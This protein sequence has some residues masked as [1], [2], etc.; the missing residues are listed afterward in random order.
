MSNL[1]LINETEVTSGV[2]TVNVTDV[3]STDF[4]IYKIT[5]EGFYAST[6]DYFYLRLINSA[7]SVIP[8][9]SYD[10]ASL[11]MRASGAF[12][13]RRGLNYTSMTHS[14]NF[15]PNSLA[16]SYNAVFY[17]FNPFSSSSYSFLLGQ[18]VES[19]Y[20][21]IYNNKS[22]GVLKQTDSITGYQ[23]LVGA[24]GGTLSGGTIRTYGLRVDS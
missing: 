7:G 11:E 1:R 16:E 14:T 9:A 21:D 18:S 4:D 6:I 2:T 23:W 12:N 15:L 19:E 24:L 5:L 22:I 17:F 13:E 3:F 8:T 10:S 20:S